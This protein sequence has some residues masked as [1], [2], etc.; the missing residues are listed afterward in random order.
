VKR[1]RDVQQLCGYRLL[2]ALRS[3]CDRN[4]VGFARRSDPTLFLHPGGESQSGEDGLVFS[5]DLSLNPWEALN[6]EYPSFPGGDMLP[7]GAS[8]TTSTTPTGN[9]GGD[10]GNNLLDYWELLQQPSPPSSSSPLWLRNGAGVGNSNK[11]FALKMLAEPPK[12]H[13]RFRRNIIDECCK[14]PCAMGQMLKYC[15]ITGVGKRAGN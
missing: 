1:S 11:A 5:P 12:T 4:F 6:L 9:F 2:D 10:G 3:V 8:S 14:K 15:A 7:Y 13:Q